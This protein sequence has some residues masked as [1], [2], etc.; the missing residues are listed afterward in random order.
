MQAQASGTQQAQPDL[1]LQSRP[2]AIPAI[3]KSTELQPQGQPSFVFGQSFRPPKTKPQDDTVISTEAA[4]AV[5]SRA[6]EK[7]ASL[8]RLPPRQRRVFIFCTC[9]SG[10]DPSNSIFR[11]RHVAVACS[12]VSHPVRDLLLLLPL[13][14][15]LSSRKAKPQPTQ[16][17]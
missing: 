13:S 12:F 7:S 16:T 4:H 2:T 15:K 9:L 8:P 10:C 1:K 3:S 17:T 5:V 14:F 6:V 11:C